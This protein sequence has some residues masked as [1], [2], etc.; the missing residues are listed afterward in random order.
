MFTRHKF[1]MLKNNF[2]I[3]VFGPAQRSDHVDISNE[4]FKKKTLW[5]VFDKDMHF[6]FPSQKYF[7]DKY[8]KIVSLK[9][10]RNTSL[11]SFENFYLQLKLL[12]SGKYWYVCGYFHSSYRSVTLEGTEFYVVTLKY[13]KYSENLSGKNS[14]RRWP[15]LSEFQF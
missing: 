1:K 14:I 4:T 2:K 6:L 7:V 13:Q 10:F 8:Y 3:I 9:Y 11:Y 5:L 15:K 12:V